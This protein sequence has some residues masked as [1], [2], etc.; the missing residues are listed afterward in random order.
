MAELLEVAISASK[1]AGAIIKEHAYG[2][3]LERTKANARDLLTLI[4]PL[5]EKVRNRAQRLQGEGGSPP[6]LISACFCIVL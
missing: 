4:D 2:A 3:K 1:K 5:C 6:S